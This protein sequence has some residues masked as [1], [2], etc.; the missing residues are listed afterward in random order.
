MS[1]FSGTYRDGHE[2]L[3]V[4]CSHCGSKK[5]VPVP[6]GDRFCQTCNKSRM[7]R[8][9]RRLRWIFSRVRPRGQYKFA[10]LT[11]TLPSMSNPSKMLDKLVRSFRI[12]R[13][14]QY[15][16]DNVEGG[17]FVVEVKRGQ[18]GHG[19][20]LHIHAIL[21]A[22]RLD[23]RKEGYI[24]SKW[25]KLT[26]GTSINLKLVDGQRSLISYVTKYITK[27]DLTGD[28]RAD[29]SLLLK[30][31]RLFQPFGS[32]HNASL[33]QKHL[34]PVCSECGHEGFIVWREIENMCRTG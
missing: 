10:F 16:K 19:W 3:S 7:M 28:D 4:L 15:W 34:P 29:V 2:W 1:L 13:Q 32:F 8:T 11:L 17:L 33:G 31:R 24:R 14:G 12:L 20:H 18:G 22:R 30:G 27:T 25:R 9:R 21:L 5:V 6:C 26:G 23:L